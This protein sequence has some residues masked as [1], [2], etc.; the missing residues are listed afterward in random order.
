MEDKKIVMFD[1][2]EAATLKTVTGW[3]S[4][5]GRFYGDDERIARY[6]GCTHQ[7]CDQCE[8]IVPRGRL[9]CDA[10]RNKATAAKYSALEAK[11]WDGETPLA[12]FDCDTYFFD[13]E[14]VEDYCDQND[15]KVEDL[16]LVICTP[17]KPAL[18]SAD[19]LFCDSLPEDGETPDAVKDAVEAVNQAIIAAP[20][21]SW[22]PGKFRAVFAQESSEK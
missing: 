21:F 6:A 1:S 18:L 11:E 3:V 4:R 7:A 2:S 14:S 9:I 8:A 13:F 17:I 20:P 5:D 15:C 22:Y 12:L 10:C 16:Q 19:D